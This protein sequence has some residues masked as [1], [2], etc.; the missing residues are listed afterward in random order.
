ML[1]QGKACYSPRFTPLSIGP[2][3][4]G[5]CAKNGRAKIR[6][7]DRA[8]HHHNGLHNVRLRVHAAVHPPPMLLGRDR[9]RD[10]DRPGPDRIAEPHS[11]FGGGNLYVHLQV[12]VPTGNAEAL[13]DLARQLSDH[14]AEDVRGNVRL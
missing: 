14:Y 9:R 13:R 6:G 7:H 2:L 12:V 5:R 11:G 3:G 10:D 8:D 4:A 1:K